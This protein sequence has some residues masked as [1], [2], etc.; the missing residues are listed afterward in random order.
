MAA[1]LKAFRPGGL[2]KVGAL[3]SKPFWRNKKLNGTALCP[4]DFIKFTY[5]ESPADKNKYYGLLVGFFPYD[6][7][8]SLF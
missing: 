4:E 6:K 2:I 8:I 1:L 5:D 7:N 3:Y